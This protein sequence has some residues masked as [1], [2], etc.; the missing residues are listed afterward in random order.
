MANFKLGFKSQIINSETQNIARFFAKTA[1]GFDHLGTNLEFEGD[2]TDAESNA[3]IFATADRL[4]IDG[5][6]TLDKGSILEA[7]GAKAVPAQLHQKKAAFAVTG[8]TEVEQ[9][10]LNI[11]LKSINYDSE[12]ARWDANYQRTFKY[13]LI[14]KPGETA[15]KIAERLNAVLEEEEFQERPYIKVEALAG[16][17]ITLTTSDP[18]VTIHLRAEG[19]AVL[20]GR[21]SLTATDVQVGY[22][23]RNT[24][25]QLKSFRIETPASLRPLDVNNATR[26]GLPLKGGKYTSITFTKGVEREEL[27]GSAMAD[28]IQKGE[29]SFQLFIHESLSQYILAIT[30]WLN[31][32]VAK[33]TMYKATTAVQ[34]TASPEAVDTATAVAAAPYTAV[35]V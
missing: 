6:V 27:H 13:P 3:A 23:G 22:E 11:T 21:V 34:A 7:I 30:S 8:I 12:F 9:F 15:D 26:D 19:E 24:F 31:A 2:A 4:H 35:L 14:I 20:H 32:N 17:E 1:N 5:F 29:Y 10:I 18:G 28:G 25:E 33:R 16:N